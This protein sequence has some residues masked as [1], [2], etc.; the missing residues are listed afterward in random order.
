LELGRELAASKSLAGRVVQIGG[1]CILTLELYDLRDATIEYAHSEPGDCAEAAL[2]GAIGRGVK[3]LSGWAVRSA[4]TEPAKT[5][6]SPRRVTVRIASTPPQS[7]VLLD[8][9]RR[10]VTPLRLGLEQGR[11]YGLTVRREDHADVVKDF[12]ADEHVSLDV[13]LALTS[14]G[15][16]AIATSTAWVGL[17]F[18]PGFVN[19]SRAGHLALDLRLFTIKWRRFFWTIFDVNP[20]LAFDEPSPGKASTVF[21]GGTR[22]GFPLYLGRRGQHQLLFGLGLYAALVA[23]GGET[24]GSTDARA[25]FSVS[26]GVEYSYA[27]LGG[28]VPLGIGVRGQFPVAKDFGLDRYPCQLLFTLNVGFAARPGSLRPGATP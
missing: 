13:P 3:A 12:V 17:G 10:G 8:G 6:V 2:F 24:T 9:L 14:E 23:S 1:K 20:V 15:R 28:H 22:G 11:K 19:G 5:G 16:L 27:A 7:D 21:N 25:A 18:G 4:V 26:P